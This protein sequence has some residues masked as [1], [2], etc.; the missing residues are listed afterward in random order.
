MRTCQPRQWPRRSVQP[1]DV[2]CWGETV[3]HKWTDVVGRGPGKTG[4]I[5]SK[6]SKSDTEFHKVHTEFH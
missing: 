2:V 6:A 5:S 3:A 4:G 1:S